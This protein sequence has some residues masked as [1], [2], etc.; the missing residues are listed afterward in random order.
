MKIDLKDIAE[1]LRFLWYDIEFTLDEFYIDHISWRILHHIKGERCENCPAWHER[2]TIYYRCGW[3]DLHSKLAMIKR[4]DG[5]Y[6]DVP[7]HQYYHGWCPAW[8][9]SNSDERTSDENGWMRVKIYHEGEPDQR[10]Y[11]QI[12]RNGVWQCIGYEKP[13]WYPE[14]GMYME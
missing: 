12:A 1:R 5:S 10:Y 9:W 14:Y 4:V 6:Y 3:C 7:I 13:D 2:S 8:G 11:L